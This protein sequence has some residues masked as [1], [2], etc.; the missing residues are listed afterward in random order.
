MKDFELLVCIKNDLLMTHQHN[1]KKNKQALQS[2]A[3]QFSNIYNLYFFPSWYSPIVEAKADKAAKDGYARARYV[4]AKIHPHHIGTGEPTKKSPSLAKIIRARGHLNDHCGHIV[5][6]LLGGK[7]VDVNLFPQLASINS[8]MQRMLE[9]LIVIFLL[10]PH[11][12]NPR[13]FMKVYLFYATDNSLSTSDRPFENVFH[14]VFKYDYLC[15]TNNR[16]N[17]SRRKVFKRQLMQL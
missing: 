1:D 2:Y 5:A 4:H 9:L 13:V 14:L 8:G 16:A 7:M 11:V 6:K 3:S 10:C 12:K 15:N 17:Y